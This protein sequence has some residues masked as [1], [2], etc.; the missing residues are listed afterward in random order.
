M[1]CYICTFT[2]C[3]IGILGWWFW[4]IW[5]RFIIYLYLIWDSPS[6]NSDGQ[7]SSRLSSS[8]G[9]WI[10]RWASEKPTGAEGAEGRE[11]GELIRESNSARMTLAG[12]G[13]ASWATAG[14]QQNPSHSLASL[15]LCAF[16]CN[17]RASTF[18]L[19]FK[20][21]LARKWSTWN[22]YRILKT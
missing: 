10:H 4:W 11:G 3:H 19:I 14:L 5:L 15:Y 12:R 16:K 9:R 8:H 1:L 21:V 17:W 18:A 2:L 20:T 22:F 6:P 7:K 13:L